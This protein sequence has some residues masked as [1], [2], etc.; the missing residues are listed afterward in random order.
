M[1][2]RDRIRGHGYHFGQNPGTAGGAHALEQ[3]VTLNER[4]GFVADY[5]APRFGS[6]IRLLDGAWLQLTKGAAQLEAV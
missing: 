6:F 2:T 3:D 4:T 5:Q 1:S